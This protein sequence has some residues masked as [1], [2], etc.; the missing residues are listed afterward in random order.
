MD[1]LYDMY[2]DKGSKGSNVEERYRHMSGG[3]AHVDVMMRALMYTS[4]T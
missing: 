4:T 3:I 2:G 1:T